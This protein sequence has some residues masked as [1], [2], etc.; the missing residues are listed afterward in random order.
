MMLQTMK[1]VFPRTI[2]VLAGYVF[3]GIAFGVSLKEQGYGLPWAIL[4]S[5]VI[6]A[7]SMQFA[8]LTPMTQS[9]APVTVALMTLLVNARHI[10]YGLSMLEKYE[11]TGKYK[12]YLIFGLT[13]ETYSLVCDGAPEDVSDKGA[14]YTAIS[15][16]DQC[17]WL[18]GSVL[19]SLIGQLL[20]FDLTGID[21]A[22]TALFTVIVTEQ[23]AD[24]IKAYRKGELSLMDMAFP[25]LLGLVATLVSLLLV[26]KESF[27]LCAMAVMLACF[28]LRYSA[29]EG[30][31]RA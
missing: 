13:D 6:Y 25:T 26:G 20:P 28:F 3:L 17:Y 5:A 31:R 11:K 10:F 27:L 19:G 12:P 1:K 29:D 2:P 8:I 30:R 24:A 18:L 7:G 15:A 9:F 14:W 21:F 22:M 4:M 16:M 23:T